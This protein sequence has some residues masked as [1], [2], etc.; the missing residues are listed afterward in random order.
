MASDRLF[1]DT[2][3]IQARFSPRDKFHRSAAALDSQLRHCREIWTT[4]AV[5]LE[6]GAVFSDPSD[7]QVVTIVWSQLMTNPVFRLATI[8]GSLLK[9]GIE[10]F[11]QRADKAWSLTDCISFIV[12]WDNQLTDALTC[13]HHFTQAGFRALLLEPV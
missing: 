8:S 3:F 12:M 11:R 7:R 2:S 10:L 1:V 6:V 5:L 4:D 9:R 13:D